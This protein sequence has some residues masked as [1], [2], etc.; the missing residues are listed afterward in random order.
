M[1]IGFMIASMICALWLVGSVHGSEREQA[2]EQRIVMPVLV[3]VNAT[4]KVIGITPAYHLRTDMQ[5]LVS[6]AVK[7]MVN[8]PAYERGKPM[9]SQIVVKLVLVAQPLE[10]GKYSLRIDYAGAESLPYGTWRWVIDSQNRLRLVDGLAST[11]DDP[12]QHRQNTQIQN[13]FNP[14]PHESY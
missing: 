9:A 3:T 4:G 12:L 7:K 10:T 8:G 5:G 6:D 1:R 14:R 11:V 2:K 13:I